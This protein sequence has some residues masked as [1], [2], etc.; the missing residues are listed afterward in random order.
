MLL[1]RSTF[2][3]DKACGDGVAP[4]VLDILADVGVTGLLADRTPVGELHLQRGGVAAARAMAR[5]AWVVPR[6]L[7]DSRLV[8]AAVA[9]GAHLSQHRVRSIRAVRGAVQLDADVLASVVVGADGAHSV[10]RTAAG[11]PVV[12]RRALALRGYGAVPVERRGKQLIVFSKTRQ[13]AYAWSFDR[14]D[15]LAN[16]GYGE[17]VTAN[18]PT[19]SRRLLLEQLETLLPGARA[20][21]DWLG[22][23]LPLS[24]FR[25]QQPDGRVLLAGDAAGLVNPLTGEGIYYAVATGILAGRATANAL[26]AGDPAG[27]G[28]RHRLAVGTLLARHLRHTALASRLVAVPLVADRSLR[29]AAKDQRVFDDLVEVGLARGLIT[30][31]VLRGIAAGGARVERARR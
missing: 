30:P 31:R 29:A 8:A 22:H 15:G 7:L 5:P 3:R 4:Q 18:R 14:G 1:D 19:L 26:S 13:P 20:G 25:W 9:A 16:V 28:S 23:H 21:G 6:T 11:A 24:S 27:A 10:L 2:P 17:I 12:R